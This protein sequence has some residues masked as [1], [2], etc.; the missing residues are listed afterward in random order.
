MDK[1]WREFLTDRGATIVEDQV[2][3]FDHSVPRPA[4]TNDRIV[5]LSHRALIAVR[6]ADA[7]RFLQGQL[8]SDVHEVSDRHTQLSAWCSPK[9]RVLAVLRV[10]ARGPV[11]Y[12]ECPRDL[13]PS[14]IQRL[15]LYVLRAAVHIEDASDELVRV[16][17]R[18]SAALRFLERDLG[19]LPR[20][21]N[22]AALINQLSAVRIQAA[23]DRFE[24]IGPSG[25]MRALWTSLEEVALPTTGDAWALA[26]I[27][28]GIPEIRSNT[29]DEYLP[30]MLNLDLIGGVSFTKGCYVGQEIVART[31][32]LGRL[33][34]RMYRFHCDATDPPPPGAA[35]VGPARDEPKA[36]GRVL[37]AERDPGGGAEALVVMSMSDAGRQGLHVGSLQGTL[38]EPRP[39]P[40]ALPER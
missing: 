8:T 23:P 18:G 35:I 7:V 10:L 4:N 6:G 20:A 3:C 32:H 5:D 25:P 19:K 28:A 30:Q 36:V 26:D 12:L 24:L 9:G 38:V 33:K 11:I 2:A 39:L 40:Y 34:R 37:T 13:C 22:D 16:G 27:E 21:V 29:V 14:L 15:R 31:Q 17:V 1:K